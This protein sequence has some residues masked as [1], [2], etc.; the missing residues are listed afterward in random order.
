MEFNINS[1]LPCLKERGIKGVRLINNLP[2][3]APV[4]KM[5]LL[6]NGRKN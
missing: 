5:I 4:I 1:T 6:K 3:S 2:F